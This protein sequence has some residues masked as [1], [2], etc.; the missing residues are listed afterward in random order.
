MT[1]LALIF[2]STFIITFS[3]AMMPGPLLS[4]TISE[5]A[6]R[7]FIAGPLLM[8]GHSI[9][10]AVLV[11]A[12]LFGLA[13]FLEQETVKAVIFF[14]G[15][16]ILLWMAIGMFHNLPTLSLPVKGETTKSKNLFLSGALVS[17]ANPYWS[18]W[19][20]T[21]GLGLI[22]KFRETGVAGFLCFFIGHISADFVWYGAVAAA[23]AKGRRFLND[24]RYR[25]LIG[26]CAA[27]LV[28]FAASFLINAIQSIAS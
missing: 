28:V 26:A 18:V 16:A 19:W 15:T 17:M 7:G 27:F 23:V 20:A 22:V 12:L 4:I 21:I 6:R 1:N 10:E 8:I 3:G 14:T 25:I 11:I 24:R 2:F 13:P 5:S 9:L